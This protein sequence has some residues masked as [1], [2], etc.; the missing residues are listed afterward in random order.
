L[1]G[2]FNF[3]LYPFRIQISIKKTTLELYH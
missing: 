3:A 1:M 2:F